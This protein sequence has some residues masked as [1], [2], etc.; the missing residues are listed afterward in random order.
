[1]EHA[2]ALLFAARRLL[3]QLCGWLAGRQ[4][5]VRLLHWSAEHDRDRR[6]R[7]PTRFEL[8]LSDPTRDLDRLCAALRERLAAV[9]LPAPAHTLRLECPQVASLASASGSLFPASR[10]DSENLARLVERLQ[11]RLGREQVQRL[12]LAADHRPEAAY[13][14]DV[15]DDLAALRSRTAAKTQRSAPAAAESLRVPR[16][17]WLLHEPIALAERDQRPWWRGPLRLLTPPER[18]ESGWWDD[19]LVQRDYFIAENDQAEWFWIYRVRHAGAG[20]GWYL[21]GFFG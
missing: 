20:S 12:L 1:V 17:L 7:A 4:A 10:S 5:A 3:A 14:I 19:R 21:Q 15:V 16:P 11:A 9:R 6:G 2:D 8:R 13:R 18:I